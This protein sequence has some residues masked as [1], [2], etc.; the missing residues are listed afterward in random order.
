MS[1]IREMPGAW[2]ETGWQSVGCS[3]WREARVFGWAGKLLEPEGMWLPGRPGNP[4]HKEGTWLQP[5]SCSKPSSLKCPTQTNSPGFVLGS[6]LV[7]STVVTLSFILLYQPVHISSSF[8]LC[9]HLSSFAVWCF[10]FFL[11]FKPLSH[12]WFILVQGRNLTLFF[13]NP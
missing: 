10:I 3:G 5:W 1:W 8:T 2:C 12:L 6:R 9:E 7:R 4:C 13:P 11:I